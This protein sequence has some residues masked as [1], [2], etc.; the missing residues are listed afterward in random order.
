MEDS[1][2]DTFM[3]DHI[4]GGPYFDECYTDRVED[5]YCDFFEDADEDNYNYDDA[6][7]FYGDDL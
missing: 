2:L 5:D 1:Y 3:E 7:D 4:I 6:N